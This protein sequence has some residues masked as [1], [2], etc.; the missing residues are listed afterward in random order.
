LVG[1][2]KKTNGIE[3]LDLFYWEIIMGNWQAGAT[4]EWDIV[5]D[6]LAPFNCRELLSTLLG[7]DAKYRDH[8][9]PIWYKKLIQ[10]L[11]PGLLLEPINPKR[12]AKQIR[13]M[14]RNLLIKFGVAKILPRQIRTVGSNLLESSPR[15]G[16]EKLGRMWRRFRKGLVVLPVCQAA[17]NGVRGL[18]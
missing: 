12:F 17:T 13:E 9:N 18:L 15:Y 7:V 2:A 10:S 6:C 1:R 5:Q 16:N 11:W 3:L 4:L 14:L 8:D